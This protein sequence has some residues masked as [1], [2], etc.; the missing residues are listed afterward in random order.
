MVL[1]LI[2]LPMMGRA[3]NLDKLHKDLILINWCI[4]NGLKKSMRQLSGEADKNVLQSKR[5][6]GGVEKVLCEP[7]AD[8]SVP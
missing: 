1:L 5:C 6:M 7:C 4:M 2:L 8:L 3:T